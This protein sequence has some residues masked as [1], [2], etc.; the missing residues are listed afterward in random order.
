M[1]KWARVENGVVVELITFDPVGLFHPSLVWVECAD[2][3][4]VGML[5]ADGVFSIDDTPFDV[6]GYRENLSCGPLQFRKALRAAGLHTAAIAYVD[7]SDD[8]TKE[9]WE[10]ASEFKRLDP[11]I[12]S[13]QTALGKTDEEVD[14]LFQLALTF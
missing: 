11:F 7:A 1:S 6:N 4:A 13:A 12:L 8:E 14:A 9:A 3:V 5:Y 2:S 10:Y